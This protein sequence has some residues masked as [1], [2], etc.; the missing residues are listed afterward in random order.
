MLIS[1]FLF[2]KKKENL[3]PY[4]LNLKWSITYKYLRNI[5]HNDIMREDLKKLWLDLPMTWQY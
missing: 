1:G 2:K 3:S 5:I 4:M